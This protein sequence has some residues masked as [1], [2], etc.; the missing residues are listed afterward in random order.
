MDIR[1][2][3]NS[4]SSSTAS[5]TTHHHLVRDLHVDTTPITTTAAVD[6]DKPFE[7]TWDHCG[8]CFSRRSD[9]SRHRRIHT[10]ERPYHCEW[11]GCGKQFIQ[12]S[13]LT[14][15]MRTHTG[16][17]PHVCE[18]NA[19]GK[20]FSDSSSLARHR[21]THTGKRPYVCNHCGKSFTRKTTLSRHQRCHDP[22]W[23]HIKSPTTVGTYSPMT[24]D[25]EADVPPS[26]PSM[27]LADVL[28]RPQPVDHSRWTAQHAPWYHLPPA[29]PTSST[30]PT[31]YHFPPF[32]V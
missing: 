14:V 30:S 26:P 1:N 19:C 4:N 3:L 27:A 10:G 2:L 9:L 22:E 32:K 12:R 17:R 16:E 21:R 8:K 20:S 18:Y 29:L 15:H 11:N 31:T 24:S 28:I 23:K 6:F 5:T 13:A 7:C 25:S